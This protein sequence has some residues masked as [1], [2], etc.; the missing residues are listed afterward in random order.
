[1]TEGPLRVRPARAADAPEIFEFCN[2][3][4]G[5]HRDYVLDVW[6]DWLAEG[7]LF[8]ATLPGADD[9]AVAL[10]RVRLLS[11]AEAWFGG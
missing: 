10:L 4:W 1:M 11:P 9:Q 2:R 8:A 3:L 6:D 7:N 5:G